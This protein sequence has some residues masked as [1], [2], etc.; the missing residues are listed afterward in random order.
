VV[1][2][3]LLTAG[4]LLSAL[5]IHSEQARTE[6]EKR[7]AEEAYQREKLRSEEAEARFALARRSVDEMF[8]ISQEELA[9][10]PGLE[11]LRKRMLWSVLAFYQEFLAQRKDDPKA[12]ADLLEAKVRVENILADLA[13]L[14]A[15][16]KL[17]LLHQPA[18]LDDLQLD[19]KQRPKVKDF[20]ARVG[21]EWLESLRLPSA[22]RH[23]RDVERSRIYE[24]E[25]NL[26]LTTAQRL[27]LRQIGLQADGP[28]AFSEPE[29]IAELEL[30]AKQREQIRAI[31]EDALFGWMRRPM[32]GPGEKSANERILA[33]LTKEQNQ[34][35]QAMTGMP[36]KGAITPFLPPPVFVGPAG[37]KAPAR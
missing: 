11:G 8:R 17:Y 23:R 21:K 2:L 33:V 15:A 3:L 20:C 32:P 19:E 7:K 13:V 14:R 31:E 35:W 16:T 24:T 37:A 6:I 28:V 36:V 12:Q 22:E 18:V 1:M 26:L 5:L 34:R 9:D 30:T 29:V 10:R 25:L 4:S 27:R